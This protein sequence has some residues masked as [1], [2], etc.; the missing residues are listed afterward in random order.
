M[1]ESIGVIMGANVGTTITAWLISIFG[2]KVKIAD[3]SLVI[4]GIS[5]PLLFTKN[6]NFRNLAETLIGFALL[7]M[8]LE[9]LKE[10]LL[11]VCGGQYNDT[12]F[13]ARERH[14]R[15]I[16]KTSFH[17]NKGYE[18][19]LHNHSGE[20]LA[21]ELLFAQNTLSEVTTLSPGR[22]MVKIRLNR[23]WDP[24]PAVMQA[25]PPSSCNVS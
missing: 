9:A 14:L 1:T 11:K 19:L 4:I 20:I 17:L 18:A 10:T 22:A 16:Q 3:F 5:F 7:F 6:N 2:F 23:A 13:S 24:D 8:G 21:E 15:A 25:S 12:G